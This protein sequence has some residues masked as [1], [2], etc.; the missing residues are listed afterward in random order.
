MAGS[1][2]LGSQKVCPSMLVVKEEP[3]SC[4]FRVPDNVT[5]ISTRSAFNSLY[6]NLY[7]FPYDLAIDLNNVE[8]LSGQSCFYYAFGGCNIVSLKEKI[9]TISNRNVF[10]VCFAFS[11]IPEESK[12]FENLESVYESGLISGLIYSTGKETY[13]FKKLNYIENAGLQ[14]CFGYS[15]AKHIYFDSL[16]EDSFSV[17]EGTDVYWHF[18]DM[19]MGVSDCT[20]HFPPNISNIVPTLEGYPS[21]GGTNTVI[22]YDLPATE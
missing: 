11:N 18:V 9:K 5:N 2:Y 3:T 19:L 1:L 17:V 20:L 7:P 21:F 22:L 10:D 15:S 13:R 12:L 14:A 6:G 8:E 16:K 4:V